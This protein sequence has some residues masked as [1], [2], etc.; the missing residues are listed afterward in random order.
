MKIISTNNSIIILRNVTC[1]QIDKNNSSR[2][3]AIMVNN[4]IIHID[5]DSEQ[6]AKDLLNEIKKN[7]RLDY[8][9]D[10]EE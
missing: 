3:I 8:C 4:N 2:L 10:G 9:N 7:I 1:I 6:D 5:T